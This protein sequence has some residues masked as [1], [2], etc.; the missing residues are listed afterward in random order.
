MFGPTDW[1]D[2]GRC[3]IKNVHSLLL[4][5]VFIKQDMF[6][7]SKYYQSYIEMNVKLSFWIRSVAVGR[8]GDIVEN[9]VAWKQQGHVCASQLWPRASVYVVCL[10]LPVFARLFYKDDAFIHRLYR[11]E[12]SCVYE[13]FIC[14][15][16]HL[17]SI[18]LPSLGLF[19]VSSGFLQGLFWQYLSR[20]CFG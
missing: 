9:S 11:P 15:C 10:F 12:S 18:G 2:W 16:L 14:F 17:W 20:N 1:T 8:H 3:L 13:T 19:W 5:P 4:N 6:T 7:S